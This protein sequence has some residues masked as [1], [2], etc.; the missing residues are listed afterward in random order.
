[1]RTIRSDPRNQSSIPQRFSLQVIRSNVALTYEEAQTRIDDSSSND[2]V[3]YVEV[4][5]V[6]ERTIQP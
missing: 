6:E 4:E 3:I 1:M 5:V 2:K